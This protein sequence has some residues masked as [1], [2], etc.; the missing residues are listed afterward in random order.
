MLDWNMVIIHTGCGYMGSYTSSMPC[1]IFSLLGLPS[2]FCSA[3]LAARRALS[4]SILCFLFSS[5]VCR[6]LSFAGHFD[7]TT[8]P[9]WQPPKLQFNN[10]MVP[11]LLPLRLML[12]NVAVRLPDF[13]QCR[14]HYSTN[15][16]STMYD[17][18]I[19]YKQT[20]LVVNT[21]MW[22]SLRLV[23]ISVIENKEDLCFVCIA[24]VVK[25]WRTKKK[26]TTHL[27]GQRL[28]CI[29]SENKREIA[30]ETIKS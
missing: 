23:Q 25:K 24:L 4:D 22:S 3:V 19:T 27:E 2:F 10:T 20:L 21:L 16:Y 8:V 11:Y 6:V 9:Y 5:I 18:L 28:A 29:L 15:Y 1:S 12:R 26:F 13:S 7:N 30:S 14:Y 17:I